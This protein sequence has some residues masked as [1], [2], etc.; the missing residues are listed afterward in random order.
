MPRLQG[1]FR[2]G[3]I[4]LPSKD[5]RDVLIEKMMASDRVIFATPNYSFHVSGMMKVFLDRLGFAFHRPQFH[6]KTFTSIVAQGIHGGRTPLNTSISRV[7]AWASTWSEVVASRRWNRRRRRTGQQMDEALVKHTR[8][9]HQR[10]MQPAYPAPSL[11][12]LMVFRM[13][14]T[15]IRK[16]LGDSNR[17]FT[18]YRDH[19]WFD[20]DDDYPTRLGALK[21]TAGAG[22]DRMAGRMFTKDAR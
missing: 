8:R 19:G 5:D 7:A 6:G 20:S 18:Y 3:R 22:F 9:F 21:R 17:D 10:L 11:I 12:Q 1:L 14:R 2:A 4:A 13:G 15:S 16:L